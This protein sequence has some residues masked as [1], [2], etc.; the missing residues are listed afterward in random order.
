[1]KLNEN[2]MTTTLTRLGGWLLIGIGVDLFF[3]PI[4]IIISCFPLLGG[5]LSAVTSFIL[6]IVVNITHNIYLK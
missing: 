3:S 4:S 1:M 2:N 5:F 6:G